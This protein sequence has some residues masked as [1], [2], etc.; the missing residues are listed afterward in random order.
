VLESCEEGELG[1][2][3]KLEEEELSGVELELSCELLLN[4]DSLEEDK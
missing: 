2:S 3:E 1:S 4:V